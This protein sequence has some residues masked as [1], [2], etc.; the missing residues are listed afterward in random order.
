L[1]HYTVAEI[2]A[3]ITAIETAIDNVLSGGR[4]Y[5]LNDS[6]GDVQV[7]RESLSALEASRR[8]WEERL[9]ELQSDAGIVS[10]Q[11]RR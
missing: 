3:K 8:Y 2:E 7:T 10:I 5:R 6:M 11:V 1:A 9:E 4:S